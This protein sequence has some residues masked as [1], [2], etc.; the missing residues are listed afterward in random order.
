MQ[1]KHVHC[2]SSLVYRLKN[3]VCRNN[4]NLNAS[5]IIILKKAV[6]VSDIEHKKWHHSGFGMYRLIYCIMYEYRIKIIWIRK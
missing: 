4:K 5:L 1:N 3:N 2:W 6:K